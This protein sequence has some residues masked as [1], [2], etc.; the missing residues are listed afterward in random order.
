[1]RAIDIVD[2]TIPGKGR[3][4]A[5]P[6]GHC[7]NNSCGALRRLLAHVAAMPLR[8]SID[9]ERKFI[10]IVGEGDVTRADV[11]ELLDV[12]K[13]TGTRGFRKLVDIG[14]ADTSMTREELFALGVRVR[15]VHATGNVGPMALVL[16]R[17]GAAQA[18]A[19]FG[20]MAAAD[21]PMRLFRNVA[22]AADWIERQPAASD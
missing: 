11:V 20:M 16:S 5:T 10:S 12:M 6:F 17:V 15:S 14:N 13:E 3:R 1:V 7:E 19:F 18:E 8:W 22:E 21:R 9:L 2:P 4:P